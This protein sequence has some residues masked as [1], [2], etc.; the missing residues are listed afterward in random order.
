MKQKLSQLEAP[1]LA[2]VVNK[3]TVADA[4]SAIKNSI[5]AGADMIDLHLSGLDR[6]DEESLGKIIKSSKLPILALNYN[7]TVDGEVVGYSEDERVE[8]L[9]RAVKAGASGID[10]QGYTF[11]RPSQT[12][13]YGE[14]KYI[15]TKGAPKE[16][17]TDDEIISKQCELIEKVH[18]M[19]AE[20][21]LSCHPGIP[22]TC[23]QVVELALFLEQRKPDI[24][25]IVT[26]AK[27]QEDL[28]ESIRTMTV[29]KKEIKTPITYLANG[30]A[31]SLS[32]IINPLL[33]AHIA[34]CV[35]H[36]DGQIFV[37]QP[38]LRSMRT[39]VDTVQRNI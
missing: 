31:G 8:S 1:A 35:E 29:L 4:I 18:S 32:R 17:V 20:V 27:T 6:T 24:L 2:G 15:F 30:N 22:M 12:G 23:D 26:V 10:M 28:L 11:H 34:F 13:F 33:G 16:V 38:E 37:G 9:L 5:F 25:K 39:I 7:K 3:K 21:L 14:D 36:Y 19:G